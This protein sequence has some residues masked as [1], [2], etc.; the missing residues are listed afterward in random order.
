MERR[1]SLMENS[2]IIISVSQKNVSFIRGWSRLR[3]TK[4]VKRGG[5]IWCDKAIDQRMLCPEASLLAV[6]RSN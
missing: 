3:R 4:Y 2:L 6:G 1:L 5:W